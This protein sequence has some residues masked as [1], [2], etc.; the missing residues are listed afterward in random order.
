MDLSTLKTDS[1]ESMDSILVK[2]EGLAVDDLNTIVC[3]LGRV[4]GFL[5]RDS[6]IEKQLQNAIE[7]VCNAIY[8]IDG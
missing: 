1:L 3:A 7:A 2:R 8:A 4:R 6:K 5:G